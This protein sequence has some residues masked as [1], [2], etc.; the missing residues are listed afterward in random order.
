MKKGFIVAGEASAELYAVKLVEELRKLITPLEMAGIGGDRF[1]E[2]GIELIEHYSNI[3]VVGV[4][5]V[6]S[7]LKSI[8]RSFKNTINWI[9]NSKPDFIILIDLPDFNFKII[10]KIRRW[11]SGKIIYFV[12]PQIWAWR[13]KRKFFLKKYVDK[14]IV[15]L[16]FE[17]K[18]YED[19]GF[20][21]EYL[22]HPLVDI[23]N[24]TM[25]SQTFRK[26]YN[27]NEK[28]RII[29]VFPGS[30]EKEVL[31]HLD[32][33]KKFMEKMK[34]A[35]S[36]IEFCVVPANERLKVIINEKFDGSRLRTIDKED[37]YNAMFCSDVVVAKSGTTT[38]EAAIAKKPAVVFYKVNK[39]SYFLAKLVIDVPYIS[40]PNLILN[41]KV[42]PEFIQNDFTVSNIFN[43]VKRF[44]DDAEIYIYTVEKLTELQHSLGDK[45]F[46]E[47]AAKKIKEWIDG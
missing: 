18:I 10:K 2:A 13:E 47:R 29:S 17:K 11:F 22:G 46:F 40:L 4:A 43:A 32:I 38:L 7:H 30:R 26:K 44:L 25:D 39:V 36:N 24:Q 41:D 45:G 19:I 35:Y 16:P 20:N 1:T 37:N 28:N 3:S 14:M 42:Y 33:L 12:S 15:I 5:E 27:I 6:I 9:K 34:L 8:N 31:S 23:V 21:V